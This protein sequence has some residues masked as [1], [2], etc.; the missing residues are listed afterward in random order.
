MSDGPHKSLNMRSGWK[1]L[2]ERADQPA[3]EP[4][5][6]ADARGECGLLSR[7]RLASTQYLHR[8]AQAILNNTAA[9]LPADLLE[10]PD[11]IKYL[12]SCGL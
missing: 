8:S 9:D 3:F 5:H 10:K 7:T 11:V 6:V 12:C 1:K 2:A 4:E